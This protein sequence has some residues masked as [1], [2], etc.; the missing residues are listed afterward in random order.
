[1][2]QCIIGCD[3]GGT[4]V[5]AALVNKNGS[6]VRSAEIPSLH[7]RG[8]EGFVKSVCD[9]VMRLAQGRS[10]DAVG[11]GIAGMLDPGRTKLV[12]SPNM[13]LLNG[14]PLKQ[15][16]EQQLKCSVYI[17]NDANAA[18]LGELHA[19]AGRTHSQFLFFTLGTGIGSGLILNKRLWIGEAGKAGEFGHVTVYP[20]G[21]LCGCGRR[22]CLEAHASGTAIVRM[23]R[24]A[25]LRDEQSSLY[26][27]QKRIAEITPELVYRLA[28]AGDEASRTVFSSMSRALA[29]AISGVNNLLDIHTFIVGGGISRAYDLFY[30]LVMDELDQMVFGLSR[31]RI[32]LLR[33][34]LGNDAG[35][36]GAAWAAREALSGNRP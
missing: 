30:P 31:G 7:K 4:A 5:K 14:I 23:A 17:E 12:N 2:S 28:G 13:P 20:D 33:A 18:A 6:I 8:H 29:I 35:V 11:L 9:L 22:G 34:Q 15:M 24:D 16:L 21:E 25:A 26:A 1:V 3:I 27:Y 19:G 36:S 32:N 10:P